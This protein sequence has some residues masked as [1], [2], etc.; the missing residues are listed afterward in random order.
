MDEIKT[1]LREAKTTEINY[2]DV[3]GWEWTGEGW[4]EEELGIEHPGLAHSLVWDRHNFTF[5]YS[6]KRE[7]DGQWV[8]IPCRGEMW[9]GHNTLKKARAVA[10]EFIAPI[11]S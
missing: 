6:T 9:E 5:M 4:T 8:N 2:P 7:H 3:C 10:V 1:R 11:E